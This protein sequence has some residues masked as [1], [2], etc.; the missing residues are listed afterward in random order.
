VVSAPRARLT[1]GSVATRRRPPGFDKGIFNTY[2]SHCCVFAAGYYPEENK[3]RSVDGSKVHLF[4][5][6][7]TDLLKTKVT[8]FA[9]P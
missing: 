2:A 1:E 7:L 5:P 8:V 9:E 3:L 4:S 6:G